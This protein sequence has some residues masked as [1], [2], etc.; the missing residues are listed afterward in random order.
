MIHG[1]FGD[2]DELFFEIELIDDEQLELPVDAMLDTGFSG[3]LA[4]EKQ[5]L[6]G[7][8]WF[9]VR[10]ELMRLAQGGDSEF[11]LYAGKVRI[12][13]EEFD[14]PVHVGDGVPEI[15]IGR[16]WLKS[17]RLVVDMQSNVLTLGGS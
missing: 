13:G 5:D 8:G 15:L 6:E 4:I 17:R 16:Q 7:L 12:D 9:Y 3:W 11:D 10:K 14:I 1:K 2:N